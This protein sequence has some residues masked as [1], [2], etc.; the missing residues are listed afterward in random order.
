MKNLIY[1][2]TIF[3]LS[4]CIP[5]SKT[6]IPEPTPGQQAMI[7]RK[8]GM[9]LHY[10]MNTYLNA[11]WSDGTAAPSTYNPPADIESKAAQWVKNAKTAG[12]RSIVLTTKHHDGFC[13]WDS[14]YTNYDIANPDI[15]IKADIVRAVSDACQ[16]EGIA[17][18]IYYSLWDRHEPLYKDKDPYRYIVFMK[19]QLEELMT[20]YGPIAELWFDGAWDRRVEDWHLQEVYDHVKKLQPLCQISTNWT[21]GKRPADMQEGDSIIFFPSDFRLWDPFLPVKNDPKIYTYKG[22]EYYLPF[23]CTQTISVLGNWFAHPEDTTVRELEEL[24]EIFYVATANDN[25]LLLNIPPNIHGE[26]NPTAIQRINQLAV[27]HGFDNGKDFPEKMTLPSSLTAGSHAEATSIWKNDTIH[28]GP[29]NAIDSDMTWL[30]YFDRQHWTGPRIDAFVNGVP[31][32][33]MILLDY[34]AENTEIWKRTES[35]YGQ[36][37][38]WCYLGNF[39]GNTM[40][41]GNL[42]ETGKRIENVYR[43]GGTNFWGIGSTLESFDVNPFMYEYVFEKAWEKNIDD[44]QWITALADRR[45]GQSDPQIRNAWNELLNKVYIENAFLGQGPLTNARPTLKGSGTWTVNPHTAY[46]NQDLFRIWELLLQGRD[47]STRDTY[48]FDVVN[49]G[50]QV[51]S[52]YFLQVRD[53]FT[54]AYERKDSKELLERGMEMTEILSDLD[55]LLSCHKTFSFGRWI[56]AAEAFGTTET[57]KEYYKKNARTLLTTWG[58]KGQSL[59]DYANRS[60]S[61]LTRSY[62]APRWQVFVQD[63]YQAVK[64]N[65]E[66]DEHAFREKMYELEADW[67]EH[68]FISSDV[69]REDG[70]ETAYRL[71]N[72]YKDRILK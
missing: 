42:R 15:K 12:M 29:D 38:L 37:Y 40:M 33:K 32:N 30:F 53:H 64:T 5:E 24:E 19:N 21:I 4:S 22:K 14:K 72:K 45:F 10:G 46:K 59:N 47:K 3:L 70:I 56:R 16:K 2:A 35:Y 54:N 20:Q 57:E 17:F 11:E 51:I 61:G 66:F 71:M 58:E 6:N 27:L 67:M 9:F 52:N 65:K 50:R 49:T 60:W 41:T 48:V 25:C 63:V 23:E 39:G 8:Y 36:P 7:E 34:Y 1:Y 13:L 26:Q 31:K 18:S 43:N 55:L 69:P 62:Y 44:D 28:H 68:D